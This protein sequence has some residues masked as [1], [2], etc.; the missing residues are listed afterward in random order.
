MT[1]PVSNVQEKAK[2]GKAA[3]GSDNALFR[4]EW[5]E[6]LARIAIAKY[7]KTH[8]PAAAVAA[9]LREHVE[10]HVA[11]LA[12]VE[13]NA[14][15]TRRLYCEAVDELLKRHEAALAALYS[16]WRLRPAGGGLR[17]KARL[18]PRRLARA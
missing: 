3:V 15:R 4:Y 13:L 10:C 1:K 12:R 11:P 9:L 8:A 14:F 7:G 16:R 6:A 18:R 17:T 2:D 5:L